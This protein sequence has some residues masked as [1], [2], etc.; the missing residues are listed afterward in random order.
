MTGQEQSDKSET[1]VSSIC[2]TSRTRMYPT[3]VR[4]IHDALRAIA[5]RTDLPVQLEC[6]ASMEFSTYGFNQ[7][8]YPRRPSV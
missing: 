8:Y 7:G 5:T 3:H 4:S 2:N 6:W 1:V